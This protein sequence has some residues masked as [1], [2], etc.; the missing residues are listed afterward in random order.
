[1]L[2]KLI[3]VVALLFAGTQPGARSLVKGLLPGDSLIIYQ[4]VVV[5]PSSENDYAVSSHPYTSTIRLVVH[6]QSDS[7]YYAKWFTTGIRDFPNRKF[8]GL[9]IRERPYWQFKEAGRRPLTY[10]EVLKL[11]RLEVS[12]REAMEYDYP[13]TKHTR[14]QVIVK[15]GKRFRQLVRDDSMRVAA[16]LNLQIP[17]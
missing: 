13:V 11:H 12:G 17:Y 1:M 2:L 14:N 6:R 15:H 4:C 8:S 5:A 7:S 16:L 3:G 10:A 9:K